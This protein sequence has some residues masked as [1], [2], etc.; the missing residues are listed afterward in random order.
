MSTS[1]P[2]LETE[3]K[4]AAAMKPAQVML[5]I[6][7]LMA[8]MFTVLV[9][10]TV[11]A[12]PMP[13]IVADLHGTNTQ[14]TWVLV[15]AFLSMT[16]ST[17]IWGKLSDIFNRKAMLQ[18]ALVIFV[19]GTVAA[20]FS[21]QIGGDSHEGAMSWLIGW[22]LVQSIGTGGLMALVQVV[23]ADIISPRERGK[24]MGIMGAVMAVGQIGGPLLGGVIADS[25]GWEWCFFVC[26]P[27]AVGALILIQ[28]TL[29]IKHVRKDVKI[30]FLGSALIITGISLLLIWISLGGK[31]SDS[32]GFAWDSSQSITM[33][34]AAGVL[35]IA[36]VFWELHVKEP[37]IPIRLFAQ[38]T[39]ALAS[40]ASIAVGVTMFGTSVFLSQYLQ[41]ARGFTPT[42]AGLQTLP[43]VLGSMFGAI[44]VGQ[45]ISRTGRWKKYVVGGGVV[46]S[47]GL[48]LMSRIDYDTPLWF[49]DLGMFLLGL[50]SGV[51]MQ[52]LVLVTQ[53][54]LPPRMIGA[55][56]GAIAF[57]RSLGGTIG[58]SV[59]GSVL[60]TQV[61]D[62]MKD[63]L[64]NVVEEIN[65]AA[66]VPQLLVD[67]P[68]CA[69]SLKSLSSGTV[70]AINDLCEPVRNIVESSYGQSIAFLFL[71]VVPLA[72]VTLI[73]A[74]FL[75]NKPLSKK[76]ASEQIEEELGGEL[77]AL[78]PAERGGRGY[79]ELVATGAI[80]LP[81]EDEL[82]EARRQVQQARRMDER[83]LVEQVMRTRNA[84]PGVDTNTDIHQP[85]TEPTISQPLEA[86][87]IDAH[88]ESARVEFMV[89]ELQSTLEKARA[90]HAQIEE[91][92]G[93]VV[94]ALKSY[95]QRLNVLGERV[96][97]TERVQR[98]LQLQA[99]A[100]RRAVSRMQGRHAAQASSPEPEPAKPSPANEEPAG[101]A[102][103]QTRSDES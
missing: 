14:Y 20:G 75:P 16:V 19:L 78:E 27:F 82:S 46:L 32:G 103:E 95:D 62:K 25:W 22:R 8:A 93:D 34:A 81:S 49:V 68:D 61:A 67:N 84:Q 9:S 88:H 39:F 55:G 73:C 63:G 36:T 100:E 102:T 80:T 77:S 96:N 83:D 5:S 30:D 101:G 69:D 97:D 28:A 24:Y 18:I 66:G 4:P 13:L 21:S 72:I 58:V 38:R 26:V 99:R 54:S 35:I 42:H 56:S 31:D 37:I 92:V 2:P 98:E 70:P 85:G 17:P 64:A 6:S 65:K 40:I 43:M 11:I 7:G 52:N 23:I 60:G 86:A 10:S 50:G 87:E 90:A 3:A 53:N 89:E 45:L 15:A 74:I 41:L 57:F 91:Q 71:L 48:Y 33:A 59:L 29:R 1:A 51:L 76:S 44:I 94:Q 79:D 12:T 47:V